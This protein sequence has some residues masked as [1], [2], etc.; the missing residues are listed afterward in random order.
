[1]SKYVSKK[2]I[3]DVW[4]WTGGV[5]SS[6]PQ[7]LQDA[8]DNF[9]CG[10]IKDGPSVAHAKTP[11]GCREWLILYSWTHCEPAFVEP[12]SYLFRSSSG[13]IDWVRRDQ[14]A[15]DL[16]KLSEDQTS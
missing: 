11:D 10:W 16:I 15:S 14:L 5:P 2:A 4:Q 12:G 1:M 13:R 8:I 9:P 3:I 7:W 6:G